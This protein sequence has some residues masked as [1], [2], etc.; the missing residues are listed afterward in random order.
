MPM[1]DAMNKKPHI[2]IEPRRALANLE[3]P[4]P[5]QRIARNVEIEVRWHP[6]TEEPYQRTVWKTAQN[7]IEERKPTL[8][9]VNRLKE[10]TK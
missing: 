3:S 5:S 7:F 9:I 6:R 1:A 8:D 4:R 10:K 2:T